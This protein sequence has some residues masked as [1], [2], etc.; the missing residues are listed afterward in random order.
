MVTRSE[1]I[2]RWLEGNM[3]LGDETRKEFYLRNSGLEEQLALITL[4][5]IWNAGFDAGQD[6]ATR[7]LK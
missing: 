1:L 4:D 3:P 2:D 5:W 6:Q 7:E